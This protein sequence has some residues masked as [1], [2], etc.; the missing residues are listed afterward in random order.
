[1]TAPLTAVIGSTVVPTLIAQTSFMPKNQTVIE[2][3]LER[4][5]V[6]ETLEPIPVRE[7]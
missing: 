5:S 7:R 1:L 4:G 6:P 2:R 3:G